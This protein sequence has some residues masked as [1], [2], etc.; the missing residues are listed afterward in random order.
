MVGFGAAIDSVPSL[1]LKFV[2]GVSVI[3]GEV[4]EFISDMGTE[5]QTV[6]LEMKILLALTQRS[7]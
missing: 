4:Q 1:F 3:L 5:I 2:V 7:A 6:H